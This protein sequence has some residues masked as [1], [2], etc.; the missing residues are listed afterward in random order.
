MA[1]A[2]GASVI[3]S[4]ELSESASEQAASLEET[5]SSLEEIASQTRFNADNTAQAN[6]L[7]QSTQAAT[8][9]ANSSMEELTR[10]MKEIAAASEQTRKIV[11]T[12]DEIAFQTN[13]LALNAAVEAA[14]AGEA[15]AGFA[16][17][18]DEVRN[19]AMRAADAARTTSDLM[20]DIT[21]KVKRG[22]ELLAVTNAVFK[23]VS[24]SCTKVVGLMGEV[25]SASR[26][27]TQGIE[28]INQALADMNTVTQKNAAS[29]EELAATMAIFRIKKNQGRDR[30]PHRVKESY[31]KEAAGFRKPNSLLP[32]PQP[33]KALKTSPT[34]VSNN[35]FKTAERFCVAARSEDCAITQQRV[36]LLP[37]RL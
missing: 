26:E 33:W 7:M 14:R 20:G 5:S 22:D 34:A 18:A 36:R 13:L 25:A 29:S 21:D 30:G 11:K 6:E 1:D 15:G 27:Q 9:E 19:L 4:Q 16:V 2:V 23:S 3:A 24:D 10:S 37:D 35:Y 8:I 31:R 17:V 12:T 28:Q 32:V